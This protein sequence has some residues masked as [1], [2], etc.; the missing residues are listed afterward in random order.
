MR[1]FLV[2]MAMLAGLLPVS[3][4]MADSP[5]PP[6]RPAQFCTEQWQP[7]CGTMS[8]KR[9]TY[10]NSCFAKVAGATDISEGECSPADGG[11]TKP[12]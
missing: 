5:P 6:P 9:I 11:P 12:Q 7:V 10:S 4:T 1:R 2:T 8:G 3:A